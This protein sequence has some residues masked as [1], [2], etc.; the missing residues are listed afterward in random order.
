MQ[1]RGRLHGRFRREQGMGGGEE[2][3]EKEEISTRIIGEPLVAY[4]VCLLA[5][6]GQNAFFFLWKFELSKIST[7]CF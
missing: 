7:L 5:M 3:G 2:K 1:G 4:D 6:L